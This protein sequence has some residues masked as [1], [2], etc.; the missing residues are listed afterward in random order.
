MMKIIVD[1]FGGD[2]APQEIVRGAID[3]LRE[4]NGFS[5]ILTGKE[6]LIRAELKDLKYEKSRVEIVDCAEVITNDDVPTLAIRKKAD[7]SLVVA[8]KRL[9]EDP[10]VQ[11]LVSAGSTGAVL[12][13]GLFKVGRIKGISRPGLCPILPT[14]KGGKVLLVDC[15]AN[16]DCKPVN[17]C[18]FALMGTAYMSAALGV[19]NPRVGLLSNGTE[20][21]KGNELNKTA[22]PMLKELAGINFIGNVEAREILSGDVDVVVTDGFAGNIALK[23][24]EGAVGTVLKFLKKE[25]KSSFRS[26]IGALFMKKSFYNLKSTLDY[27]QSGGAVF[28]GIDKVIVKSHG[29]SM[30]KS[31]CCSI[32]QAKQVAENKLVDRIKEKLAAVVIS[33]E[34]GE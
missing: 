23:G 5:V 28:L 19:E 7:S 2:N 16:V 21:K 20:D 4:E 15:G 31:I 33:E 25:I 18:H 3:A 13:G 17:L 26:K 22:F 24:I 14:L 6:E 27:N 12:A 30:A 9:K 29:S 11:G 8:M 10:E 1:A 34:E 32:L